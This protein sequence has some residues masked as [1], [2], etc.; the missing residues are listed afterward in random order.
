MDTGLDIDCIA[1]IYLTR[2]IL[3]IKYDLYSASYLLCMNGDLNGGL[4][5]NHKRP[6]SQ[7]SKSDSSVE[8][9]GGDSWAGAFLLSA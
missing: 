5:E 8:M 3:L 2:C 1:Y 9:H 6:G 4:S 7:H